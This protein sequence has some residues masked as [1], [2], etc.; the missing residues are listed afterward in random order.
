MQKSQENSKHRF[1]KKIKKLI[2]GHFLFKNH[3]A[4]F[5]PKNHLSQFYAFMLQ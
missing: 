5:F 4:R 3:S 1:I 2:S